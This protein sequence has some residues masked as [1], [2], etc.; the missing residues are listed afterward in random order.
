MT[1]FTRNQSDAI[2][3]AIGETLAGVMEG[4]THTEINALETALAKMDRKHWRL[5]PVEKRAVAH[6][7]HFMLSEAQASDT[8]RPVRAGQA[9]LDKLAEQGYW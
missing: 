9:A 8:K 5:T 1:S 2:Y 7:L 3:L 6:A 4:F